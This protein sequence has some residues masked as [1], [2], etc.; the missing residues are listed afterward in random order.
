MDSSTCAA[1]PAEQSRL[2]S[3]TN[4][5]SDCP[6]RHVSLNDRMR[7]TT[8]SLPISF[9]QGA[10]T[11]WRTPTPQSWG[12]ATQNA[13]I[14]YYRRTIPRQ[15]NQSNHTWANALPKIKAVR[16]RY[17]AFK[18][19]LILISFD[20]VIAGK[21]KSRRRERGSE[22]NRCSYRSHFE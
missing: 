3:L 20:V 18:R 17:I 14:W 12:I 4:Q 21:K 10:E 9:E 19:H 13:E 7:P 6:I 1:F 22:I 15:T 8:P 11:E 16:M 2:N 5:I